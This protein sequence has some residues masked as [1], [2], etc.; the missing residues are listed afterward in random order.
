VN[1]KSADRKVEAVPERLKPFAHQAATLPAQQRQMSEASEE[2]S[3]TLGKI[4]AAEGRPKQQGEELAAN[5]QALLREHKCCQALLDMLPAGYLMTDASGV[6]REANRGAATILSVQRDSL[7]GKPV[8]GYVAE[9]DRKAFRSQLARLRK[10]SRL[11][12]WEVHLLPQKGGPLPAV[13][14]IQTVRDGEGKR[15]GLCWLI[16]DLT[17]HKQTEEALRKRTHEMGE[18]VKELNCLYAFSNLLEVPGISLPE[19]LQG[20]VDIIPPGWQYPEMACAR[21]LFQ[22]QVFKTANFRETRWKQS[23]P[24]R[25]RGERVGTLEVYYLERKPKCDEG[26]FLQGERDLLNALA[27]R[28]GRTI[29]RKRAEEDLQR[30]QVLFQALARVSPV[31]IF[32]TDARGDCIYVNERWCEIAGLPSGQALGQGWAQAIHPEDRELVFAEWYRSARENRPFKL[33]YRFQR[34]DGATTW[35][36]GQSM[37]E[38]IGIDEISGHVGAITDITER[39]RAEE[40]LQKA[41]DELELCVEE[42]TSDLARAIEQLAQEME[43]RKRAGEEIRRLNAE[44]EERVLQRTAQLQAANEELMAFSDS[45]SHDLRSPLLSI[46]GFS[47]VLWRRYSDRLDEQGKHMLDNIRA[48]TEKM[49]RLIDDLLAFSRWGRQ[50]IKV[51]HIDLEILVAEVFQELRATLGRRQLEFVINP[52]PSIEADPSMIRQVLIN[53][54]SNAFK[55]TRSK[56]KA[57]IEVGG[58]TGPSESIYYVKDNGV[59]F[60]MKY[61]DRL[62]GVFQRLHGT[63]KFEGTGIGL[64][65]V[66]RIVQGHGGRIWAEGEVGRGATIYFTF[67]RQS[68]LAA[69][70]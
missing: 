65:I 60:D 23:S 62:F 5:R 24:I 57:V 8:Q 36:M 31:G 19:V 54:L 51:S 53:L 59:G 7:V 14:S 9:E 67:P 45:V 16:R 15:V 46:D 20:L 3:A 38:R 2:L 56:R 69:N 25:V 42:R 43:K 66:K 34:S 61:A 52:L 13:I 22:D 58:Q 70:R 55:F 30:S 41:H 32:R 4:Q 50:E 39:R 40:V 33:E 18:R 10:A 63:R 49:R 21:L 1:G 68:G 27:G 6:V 26:P 12:D 64:A 47:M 44:L 11:Q 37:A 35:V 29:D 17:A 48:G 28:M